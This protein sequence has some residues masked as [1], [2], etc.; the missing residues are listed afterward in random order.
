MSTIVVAVDGSRAGDLVLERVAEIAGE[1]DR[2]VIV[3][4]VEPAWTG[5]RLVID[6]RDVDATTRRL[7]DARRALF[8]L[9]VGARAVVGRGSPAVVIAKVAT[10]SDARLIV[11]GTSRSVRRRLGLG[12]GLGH[13][14]RAVERLAP[15]PVL[16]VRA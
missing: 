15:C 8:R 14:L 6:Q 12:S 1:H 5:T 9:G 4:T 3:G 2:V 13:A 11:A 10:Q 7:D 16:L